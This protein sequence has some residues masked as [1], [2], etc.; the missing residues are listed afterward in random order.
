MSMVTQSNGRTT[1]SQPLVIA[2]F[3]IVAVIC[4]VW[5]IQRDGEARA[6]IEQQR[7]VAMAAESR[8]LCDKWGI[9]A[10]SQR[11]AECLDDIQAVR[12]RHATRIL[13][14]VAPY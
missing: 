3:V 4:T 8:T 14:D 10:G 6:A 13:E 1:S 12:D 11:L 2:I 5:L 7:N 9:T